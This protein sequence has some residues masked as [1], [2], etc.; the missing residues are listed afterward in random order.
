MQKLNRKLP[1]WIDGFMLYTENSEPPILFRKWAAI[2]AIASALMRKVRVEWAT[3]L[4]FYPNLYIVLVGPTATG[5][6]TAMAPAFNIID[7]LPAIKIGAQATSLQAL[8][9]RLKETNLTDI[10]MET[11]AQLYHSSMTIF[12]EEFTVFLGYHN[13]ELMATLCDWYDCKNKWRYDTISRNKEEIIGVWVNLIGG[14]TPDLIQSSLPIESIGGGL[15]GRIIFVFEE[16]KE[17]LVPHPIKTERELELRKMLIHDLEKISLL[18]GTF[19]WTEG[20][21]DLWTDWCH[22]CENS[23]PFYDSKFDGYLGRR[24]PHVMKL[25]MIVSASHGQHD[26]ILSSD[27]LTEAIKLLKEVE[28]K[29]GLVFRGV[30][31]SDLAGQMHKTI[32][33]LENSRMKE[34]PFYYFARHFGNDMDKVMMDRVLITLESMNRIKLIHRPM[35]DDIIK[36]LDLGDGSKIEHTKAT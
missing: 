9:R 12:S 36:I 18:S 11:G 25:A 13:R 1:S 15:T 31:K 27:D 7:E 29:M 35:A 8:I 26:L 20:F 6:G 17:K 10:D 14:T 33:F 32:A 24:R 3:D 5:K 4:I 21:A 23:P 28:V 2:S 19:R 16:K 22:E 34:V 30:G